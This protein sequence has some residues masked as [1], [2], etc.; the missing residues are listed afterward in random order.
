MAINLWH[1]S[2]FCTVQG[3]E[4]LPVSKYIRKEHTVHSIM[5]MTDKHTRQSA[6]R[7]TPET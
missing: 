1:H 3:E 7:Q 6:S 4:L 5:D 2:L